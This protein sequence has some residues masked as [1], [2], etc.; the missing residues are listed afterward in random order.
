MYRAKYNV[1]DCIY[2]LKHLRK[3]DKIE[4]KQAFGKHYIRETL[5][6]IENAN[7][8]VLLGKTKDGDRPVLICDA[9]APDKNNPSVAIVWMLS[10]PEIEKH[11]IRFLREAK[12]EIA[13]YDE[14]F[15]I[16]FNY[17][18]EENIKAKNWLKWLGYRF[19]KD[20]EHLTLLDKAFLQNEIPEKFEVFYRERKVKGLGE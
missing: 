19:P 14:R 18:F 4:A 5:K 6:N 11:Q 1:K 10:T 13:K 7:S 15:A 17:I 9:W 12:K 3:E 16:T 8:D 20:E 2:I